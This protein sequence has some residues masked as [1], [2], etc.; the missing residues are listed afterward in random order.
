MPASGPSEHGGVPIGQDWP[1]G[2]PWT[3]LIPVKPARL[4]KS[5]LRG[6]V[7]A[8]RHEDLVRA[9][10]L[11]TIVAAAAV[12]R[13]VVIT[14]DAKL[15][16]VARGLDLLVVSDPGRLNAALTEAA[17]AVRPGRASIAALLADLPAIQS[18]ELAQA[19][20]AAG[21]VAAQAFLADA[22][23]SGTTLLAAPAGC[24]FTPRFGPG[25]A[26]AHEAV[27]IRLSEP[28]TGWP[29]L[30]AD[31]DTLDDLRRAAEL[32][33]GPYTAAVLRNEIS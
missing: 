6:A 21:A 16:A 11:D 27:A 19:L 14:S 3:V 18:T 2:A 22:A 13:V 1:V 31:V 20:T 9:M 25:S 30:R 5:R 15:A 33:L 29:G 32:G 7:A 23:G 17:A 26:R 4:A 10:A 28:T 12:A 24:A 8:G